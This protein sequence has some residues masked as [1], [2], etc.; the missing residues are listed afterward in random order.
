MTLAVPS[1]AKQGQD[2]APKNVLPWAA[3]PRE[4]KPGNKLP[5]I[6]HHSV[7]QNGSAT[8]LLLGEFEQ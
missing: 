1:K 3:L 6:F 4:S 7:K 2:N 5:I 8:W